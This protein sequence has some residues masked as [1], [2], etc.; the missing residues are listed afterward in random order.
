MTTAEA[1]YDL[2]NLRL[3]LADIGLH[4]YEPALKHAVEVLTRLNESI[5]TRPAGKVGAD[6]GEKM[7]GWSVRGTH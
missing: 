4:S 1:I 2:N 3:Y 7:A 6:V 5:P